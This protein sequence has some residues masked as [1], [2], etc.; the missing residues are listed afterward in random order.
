MVS[1]RK[2][3]LVPI[4]DL[5]RLSQSSS[6]GGEDAWMGTLRTVDV[7]APAVPAASP[8]VSDLAPKKKMG[9]PLPAEAEPPARAP[10]PPLPPGQGG[11][12]EDGE[13]PTTGEASLPQLKSKKKKKE[14]KETPVYV[15]RTTTGKRASSAQ[16][17]E[18]AGVW[19]PPGRLAAGPPRRRWI[20]L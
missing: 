15:P 4:E 2:L 11:K 14:E 10:T 12:G 17:K 18:E 16:Q 6:T 20:H 5:E 9:P 3:A 13:E 7:P 8:V 19:R 1:V